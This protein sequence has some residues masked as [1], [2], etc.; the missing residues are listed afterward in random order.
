[1]DKYT[2][3]RDGQIDFYNVFLRR[4]NSA[5]TLDEILADSNDGVL[6]GN[7]LEFKLHV[8][9]LNTVLF[10]CIKYLSALRIKGKRVPANILIVDLNAATVWQYHSETYLEYIEKP[11]SGGASKDNSG[12]VGGSP[13]R[14][15]HYDDQ[16]DT[17]A[18]IQILKENNFTKIHIDENCV[19][20]WAISF[21]KRVPNSRKE[22]FIGDDSGKHKTIGEIRHPVHFK[23][24]IYPYNGETNVKF[25]YLMDA[26]NDFLQKKNLG[27]FYTPDLYAE[28]S[29]ELVRQ[30]IKRVPPTTII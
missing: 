3:E 6:N 19:V 29:V 18:L 10:Q 16:L 4:V 22:D 30:A 2:L 25:N 1:M 7:L 14:T 20:G 12:F 9:D 24:Y 5:L 26:L 28:K 23:D 27:A 17:E 15:L 8:T 21:Y 13:V 11:Y